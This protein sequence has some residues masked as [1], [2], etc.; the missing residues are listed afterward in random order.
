[1][2]HNPHIG[3]NVLVFLEEAIPDTPEMQRIEQQERFQFNLT[4]TMRNLREQADFIQAEFATKLGL[5][6]DEIGIALQFYVR[7]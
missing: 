7:T 5:E 2:T 1:M 3:S 4:Q 6:L